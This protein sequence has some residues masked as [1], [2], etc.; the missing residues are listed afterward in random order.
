MNKKLQFL[1]LAFSAIALT[2]CGGGGDDPSSNPAP[3]PS[4]ATP[5]GVWVG[6]TSK[7]INPVITVVE[8]DYLWGYHV[9]IKSLE[10]GLLSGNLEISGAQLDGSVTEFKLNK[11]E[12][13]ESKI[14]GSFQP[15]STLNLKLDGDVS[16]TA[17]YSGFY[18]QP[19]VM[20]SV[21]GS[22][23]GSGTMSTEN[24]PFTAEIAD[25]PFNTT[26]NAD[27]TFTL[28]A[29]NGCSA[30]GTIAPRATGKNLF[31]VTLAFSGSC[32]VGNVT[33]KGTGMYSGNVLILRTP[34]TPRTG[35]FFY[36]GTKS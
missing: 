32:E 19:A 8:D 31:D 14:S 18:D 26:I 3:A 20:S 25:K 12:S 10:I 6:K 21:T 24:G 33:L 27:G 23:K 4:A 29:F 28:P 34:N 30:E 11:R 22:Y 16:Y 17:S 13:V 1:A 36:I 5:D 7:S 15:Q 2:A 35:G 9:D